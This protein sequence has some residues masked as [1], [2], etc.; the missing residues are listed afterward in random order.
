MTPQTWLDWLDAALVLLASLVAF[1]T[2][3]ADA[4]AVVAL[5][6]GVS[7]STPA[8]ARMFRWL[9]VR[10]HY[11]MSAASYLALDYLLARLSWA[12]LTSSLDGLTRAALCAAIVAL[13][14]GLMYPVLAFYNACGSLLWKTP[15]LGLDKR[16]YF[17]HSALL[18]DP[19]TFRAVRRELESVLAEDRIGLITDIYQNITIAK[20]DAKSASPTE[21]P[22]GWRSFFLRVADRDIEE[23]MARM[24]TLAA[25]L[26][27]MPEV[28]NV[29]FSI[30]DPGASIV[31]HRGYFKGILRY[32]LGVI[33]PEPDAAWLVCGGER[34]HWHE[35]E[36]V[37]FD[38]MYVHW[39]E[40]H[41]TSPRV[42][43]FVDVRRPVSGL[44]A[45]LSGALFW[46][47]T[48]HPYNRGVRARAVGR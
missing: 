7:G 13:A 33:V 47:V 19:E 27:Q 10:V 20:T 42:V 16:R 23:N 6:R 35:G 37:L 12:V 18:E 1:P 45:L 40:N 22:R 3:L 14:L 26:R 38:D 30:L 29:L 8:L 39:V 24:P 36:G 15:P 17:A 48:H 25:A 11:Q 32:H 44:T 4:Y 28:Y 46:L 31:P 5:P 21:A 34:H 43:L 41:C 2:L 9:D